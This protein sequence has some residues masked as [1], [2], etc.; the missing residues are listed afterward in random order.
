MSWVPLAGLVAVSLLFG[1]I[2]FYLT[3]IAKFYR[4]K[5]MKGPPHQWMQASLA[6]TRAAR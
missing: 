6:G 5:F 1:M 3:L 2:G 4:Q